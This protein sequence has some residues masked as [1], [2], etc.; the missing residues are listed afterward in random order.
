MVGILARKKSHSIAFIKQTKN[1]YETTKK[2]LNEDLL[3]SR[4]V[5]NNKKRRKDTANKSI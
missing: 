1:S 4:Q 3:K 2:K 5:H